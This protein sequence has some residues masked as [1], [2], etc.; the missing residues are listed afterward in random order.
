MRFQLRMMLTLV[1][2]LRIKISYQVYENL[3]STLES[4]VDLEYI[5]TRFDD[6]T[7]KKEDSQNFIESPQTL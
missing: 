2:L 6:F 4:F 3:K 5:L 7:N 1:G